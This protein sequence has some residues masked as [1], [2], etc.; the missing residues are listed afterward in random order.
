MVEILNDTTVEVIWSAVNLQEISGYIIFYTPISDASS[1]QQ[2]YVKDREH[3]FI[4][5][6]GLTPRVKYQFQVQ[7]VVEIDGEVFLGER[8][9]V[10]TATLGIA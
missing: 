2:M 10:E 1:T 9:D 8:S 6:S 3:S 5:I 4:I 7:A